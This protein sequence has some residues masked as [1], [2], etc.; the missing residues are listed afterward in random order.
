MEPTRE[1]VKRPSAEEIA[2]ARAM[3]PEEKLMEGPRLFDRACRVMA[4]GIRHRHAELDDEAVQAKVTA[5]LDRSDALQGDGVDWAYVES[6]CRQ[7]GTLEGLQ[8]VR[9]SVQ[10]LLPSAAR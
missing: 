1:L 2:R 7:H 5:Y 10:P 3:T 8:H 4:D 9:R 6:W